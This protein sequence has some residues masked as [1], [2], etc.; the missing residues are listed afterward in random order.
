M[1]R[2]RQLALI[3]MA[4]VPFLL[5]GC[6]EEEKLSQGFYTSVEACKSDGNSD[7]VCSKAMQAAA[8]AH[9]SDSPRF[10]SR[11]ECIQQYGDAC[12][13]HTQQH[14]IWMPL[15]TGFMLSQ[16]L[17]SGRAP[18]YVAAN[19][20][21]RTPDGRYNEWYRNC[22]GGDQRWGGCSSGT[23]AYGFRQSRAIDVAPNRSVTLS[24]SGFG[25]SGSEHF[26]RGG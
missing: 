12:V 22:P 1:K 6:G 25:S 5:A 19:P 24:R 14:G 3:A 10:G 26:G 11:A 7:E 21:Y 15:L 8:E 20:V 23:G 13:E 18:S 17:H 4:Q 16:L 9:A 2:S